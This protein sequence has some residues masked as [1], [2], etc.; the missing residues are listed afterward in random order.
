MIKY[1][2]RLAMIFCMGGGGKAKKG[3][4]KKNCFE[5]LMKK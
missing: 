4:S 3:G 2:F 1:V 5:L